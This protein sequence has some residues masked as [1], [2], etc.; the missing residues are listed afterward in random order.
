MNESTRQA[1]VDKMS[2]QIKELA[3][4]V[5]L[6]KAR[7]SKNVAKAKISAYEQLENWQSKEDDFKKK[8]EEIRTASADKFETLRNEAEAAWKE[9]GKM[10]NPNNK[11]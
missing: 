10:V 4:Q 2:A 5:Q 3:A 8:L 9:L 6:T 1:Y 7:A 11:H